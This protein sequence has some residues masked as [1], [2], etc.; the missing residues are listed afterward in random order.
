MMFCKHLLGV[1]ISTQNDFIYGEFGRTDYYTRRLYIIIKYWF[2]LI[3]SD[4]RKTVKVIYSLMLNDIAE[5]PNI[6]NWAALVKNTLSNLGFFHVWVA[7]G[8]GDE[9]NF[10]SLFKQE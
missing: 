10:L 7:Q 5:R 1:K 2:K 3:R 9:K 6:Q 4:G 8:V